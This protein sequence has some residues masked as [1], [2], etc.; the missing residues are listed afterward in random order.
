MKIPP[1]IYG[2][3]ITTKIVQVEDGKAYPWKMRKDGTAVEVSICCDCSLVH[4]IEAQPR[5][6]YIRMRVWRDDTRTKLLRK[7]KGRK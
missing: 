4:I 6:G 2:D 5:K 7:K 3:T 1:K